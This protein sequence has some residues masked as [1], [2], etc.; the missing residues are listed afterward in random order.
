MTLNRLLVEREKTTLVSIERTN[1]NKEVIQEAKETVLEGSKKVPAMLHNGPFAIASPVYEIYPIFLGMPK[2]TETAE[3]KVQGNLLNASDPYFDLNQLESIPFADEIFA[4]WSGYRSCLTI[5][6]VTNQL[7]RLK[8]I[9]FLEDIY[10]TA[11][12]RVNDRPDHT[13]IEGGQ[14]LANARY[15]KS[16]SAKFNRVLRSEGIEPVMECVGFYKYPYQYKGKKLA[17]SII[18]VLGDTRLDELFYALE[19]KFFF[20]FAE[21][22]LLKHSEEKYRKWL[23]NYRQKAS[24]LY[25]DLGFITGRLKRLMDRNNQSWSDNPERT[26][27]HLG[28]VVIYRQD[29]DYLGVGLVDF[30]ASCDLRDSTKSELE[31]QQKAEKKFFLGSV[32]SKPISMRKIKKISDR[33]IIN[34]ELRLSFGTGFQVG[35]KSKKRTINNLVESYRLTEMIDILNNPA[36]YV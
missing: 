10:D 3:D 29:E 27:A 20:T 31:Q 18:K 28:N 25:H 6:P 16:Y 14:F 4:L 2:P 30:D 23:G 22:S 26:N 17:T 15:E 11:V 34:K 24:S 36:R 1:P 8:G 35:Y 12:I 33:P 19:A 32:F 13:W 9:N 7:Y 21:T 5:D